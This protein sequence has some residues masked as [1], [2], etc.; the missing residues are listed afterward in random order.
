M[1]EHPPT[2]DI[3]QKLQ[4][5][6]ARCQGTDRNLIVLLAER[7]IRMLVVGPK[8]VIPGVAAVTGKPYLLRPVGTIVFRNDTLDVLRIGIPLCLVVIPGRIG[9]LVA[10][11]RGNRVGF[12]FPIQHQ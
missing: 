6:A 4:H 7:D 1:A 3:C 11:Y 8:H 5:N 12:Q 2:V 9:V 10:R